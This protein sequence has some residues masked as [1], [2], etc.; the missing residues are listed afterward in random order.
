MARA[1]IQNNKTSEFQVFFQ[2]DQ[3]IS[4]W[5]SLNA[6]HFLIIDVEE[7]I[8]NNDNSNNIEKRKKD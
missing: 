2:L 5:L 3:F 4:R 8:S 1:T 7:T 6:C